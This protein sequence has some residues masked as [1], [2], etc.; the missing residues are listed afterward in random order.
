MSDTLSY[1]QMGT[2]ARGQNARPALPDAAYVAATAALF[3][4]GAWLGRN[5]IGG[6][7]IVFFIAAFA[8][9]IAMGGPP[10]RRWQQ[11][12]TVG[13]LGRVRAADRPGRR[14]RPSPTTRAW[15]PRALWQA[16]RGHRAVH[17]R[18]RARPG[19]ATR[20]DLTAIARISFWALLA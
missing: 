11:Q 12:L 14:H 18:V 15:H 19:D 9:L 6:I 1:Q 17:R 3:A 16:W 20:R 4:L 5:L 7:G 2:A 8:C 13:L 10:R